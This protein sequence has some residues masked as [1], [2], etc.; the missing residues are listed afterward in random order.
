MIRPHVHGN[1]PQPPLIPLKQIAR[2]NLTGHIGQLVAPAVGDDHVALGLEGPVV[3]HLAAEELGRAQRGLV[4]HHGHALGLDAL[5]DALHAR[6]AEVVRVRLYREALRAHHRRGRAGVHELGHFG[7]HLVGHEVLAGAVG[8]HDGL[9][10][11]LR[12]IL[13]VRQ[14]LLGVLGQAV[15]SVAEAGVVVMTAD[16]G[17]KAHALDDLG[18][19]KPA[20]AGIGVQLVEVSHAQRQIRVAEELHR[21]GLSGAKCS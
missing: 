1:Q 17:F 18:S 20:R 8:L 9:D 15:A 5:H 2:M 16:A 13:V 14:Q 7:E 19:I 6:C 10:Q 21:L 3:R 11:A 12:H 4:D